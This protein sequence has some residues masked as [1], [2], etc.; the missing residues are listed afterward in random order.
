MANRRHKTS[1]L[2]LREC[3]QE[4]TAALQTLGRP[5]PW[6][7]DAKASD[8]FLKPLFERFFKKLGLP[9]LLQKSDYYVLARLVPKD[10]IDSEVT[11]KLDGIVAVAK[12]AKS[13]ET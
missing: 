4:V 1:E 8:D 13:K 6:S 7:A 3:I 11:L 12:K 5:N 9:N 10:E 2:T